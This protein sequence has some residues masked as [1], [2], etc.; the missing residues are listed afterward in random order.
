METIPPRRS[1]DRG[2][3]R[4]CTVYAVLT[5]IWIYSSDALLGLMVRDAHRLAV[6]STYKGLA[7]VVVSTA[8]LYGLVHGLRER[9]AN[10][11]LPLPGERAAGVPSGRAPLL[12]FLTCAAVI[13][14]GASFVYRDAREGLR[15][16]ARAGLSA[17]ADLKSRQVLEWL[18]ERRANAETIGQ[19]PF[20]VPAVEAW[21]AR[22]APQ[23]ETAERLRARLVQA[24][25]LY[26]WSELTL[27]DG[28]GQVRLAV[29]RSRP[30][31]EALVA[32]AAEAIRTRRPV[33]LDLHRIE[34]PPPAET[35][36]GFASPLLRETPGGTRVVAALVLEIDPDRYLFPLVQAWPLPS[37]SGETLLARR[38]GQQVVFLNE[39]RHR[40]GAALTLRLPLD[41]ASTPAVQAA[42]GAAGDT[43]GSDYRGVP[44]LASIR[45]L[46]GTGWA[47]V[48]KVD[49]DE[50]NAPVQQRARLVA[51]IG[52]VLVA[53]TGLAALLWW[54][55]QRAHALLQHYR[56]EQ[57]RRALVQHYD[58][59]TRYANDIILLMDEQ[60]RI[61][62]ANDRAVAAY[63]Y[64]RE[65]LLGSSARVLRGPDSTSFEDHWQ[66]ARELGG[67]VFETVHHRADGSTFPAEVSARAIDVGGGSFRQA[68]VRDVSERKEAE[69]RILRLGQLYAALTQMNQAIVRGAS[70]ED[71]FREACRVS[72]EHGGLQFAWVGLVDEASGEVRVHCRHGADQG[73]LDGIRISVDASGP[74]GQG[75][76]GT[77]IRERRTVVANDF[78]EDPGTRP[79]R[80][81][82]ARAGV[83]ASAAL[84]LSTEGRPIGALNVYA[85]QPGYFEKDVLDLLEEMAEDVSFA[86]DTLAREERRQAAEEALRESEE[87]YRLLFSSER[88]AIVLVDPETT[89]FLDANDAF[90]SMLGHAREDLPSLTALDVTGDREGTL[91]SLRE[92]RERG[93]ELVAARPVRRKDGGLVW[94]EMSLNTFVWKGRPVACAILRDITER[95]R[96]Q[97]RMLLWSRVLEDSAEGIMITDPQGTIVTVNKAFTEITGY[98]A[99]E[100]V[101]GN[102]RLLQSG[103]HDAAFYRALWGAISRVGR[104]QGEIWNRRKSGEIYPEWLS[105]TAVRDEAFRLTHH[106]GIFADIT[107]RKQS[108]DRIEFLASHDVLTG[109]PSRALM[110]DF[111][112][113]AL[114]GARRHGTNLALLHIGLDRFKSI[115]DSLGHHA[116]DVLL[117][118]VAERL[119]TC[120]REG[121]SVARLG[122]DEFLVLL[123][124]LGRGQ[125][126]AVLAER[127]LQE[128]QHPI[129]VQDRELTF[130]A[131]IGISLFP[132]DGDDVASLLKNADSALSHAKE[133][134]RNNYQFFTPDMNVRAFEALSM[135][136]SLKKALEREEFLLVY[137]PQVDTETG[138]LLGVE[139]LIRWQ[140]RDLGL[141]LP[142]RFIPIAE[143]HGVILPI[144]EWV[145]RTA[146]AQVRSWLD[147]GLPAVPVAVNVSAL[148]FRQAG[149]VDRI[150]RI[151]E[152]TGLDPRYLELELTESIVM[153]QAERTISLLNELQE[154]GLSLS[155]DDFGTGYSSLSYLRRFPIR[156]LKID[157]S[158]VRDLTSDPDAAAIAAAIV[159]MGKSLKLRIIAE[160]VETLEQ[161]A[162]LRA[163]HCDEIQ[164]FLVGR[165]EGPARIAAILREGGGLYPRG[166]ALADGVV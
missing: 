22:G 158:F 13:G 71:V 54:R 76:T 139:A 21:L 142:A 24:R 99:E 147:A 64:P 150:R 105:I 67:I 154:M 155:I 4:V 160:G 116:G 28:A 25:R 118:R 8:L 152:E 40:P 12:V 3:L 108:E 5:S 132:D 15:A 9:A 1:V 74:G 84:P 106:V 45:Q 111:I 127:V 166:E 17:I 101:G 79:W 165:P 151:L 119:G 148:Q 38:E 36:M 102:P 88:D 32:A 92:L 162:A 59:L 52:L 6:L 90:F 112:R 63:G 51:L 2:A 20:L 37:R 16:E 39:L 75:P 81:A 146:C 153:R 129:V 73:Y 61:L 141:V 117:Q 82:A 130:T 97:E 121:D 87:K 110:A 124:N 100:A 18:A 135:E 47:M 156:K 128:I 7:F 83:R 113:Q 78:Q 77:A 149:L 26:G 109:L 34:D 157:Q 107:Q 93:Q 70:R 94:V 65:Q 44:V 89:R 143:E 48:A 50:V 58:Y 27:L 91:R 43:E 31:P 134:G 114:G 85:G 49:L 86:L 68:I 159:G 56:A 126:V 104:W 14:T 163:L 120:L 98:S 115:N 103:R 136:M 161:H 95:R 123:P 138:Q 10:P 80:E 55:Q 145:L 33:F 164:G 57:E 144:G 29:G 60:G 23:D 11:E 69:R 41:G 19:D 96:A 131:S 66:R 137:Q 46:P 30:I 72:V 62:E 42:L 35:E 125:E 133:Q 140:H 122:G 53:V